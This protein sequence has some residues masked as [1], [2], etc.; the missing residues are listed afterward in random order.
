MNETN[1]EQQQPQPRFCPICQER[2]EAKVSE[3]HMIW[4]CPCGRTGF[5]QIRVQ[6][7]VERNN[8][9]NNAA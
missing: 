4:T 5:L 9:P 1:N 8:E 7:S 6:C 3:H 2:L